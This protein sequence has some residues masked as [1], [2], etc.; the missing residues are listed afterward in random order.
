MT[1]LTHKQAVATYIQEPMCPHKQLKLMVGHGMG[2]DELL[3]FST[4]RN[5]YY[6]KAI[7]NNL[8]LGSSNTGDVLYYNL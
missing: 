1:L 5:M 4:C 3:A 7:H 8:K 2:A 6:A